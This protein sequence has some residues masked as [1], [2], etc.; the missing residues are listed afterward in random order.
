MEL[1]RDGGG[2][3]GGGRFFL[4]TFWWEGNAAAM[5][6]VRSRREPA[7][8]LHVSGRVHAGPLDVSIHT[9]D[10]LA[11]LECEATGRGEGNIDPDYYAL[12]KQSVTRLQAA[13]TP[14]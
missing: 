8:C 7:L 3:L 10:G 9:I 14:E 2:G 4:A 1:R 5:F 12:V 11:V 6:L 13:Q